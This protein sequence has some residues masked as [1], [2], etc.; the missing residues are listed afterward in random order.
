[1]VIQNKI[2]GRLRLQE[3]G[4]TLGPGQII[5]LDEKWSPEEQRKSRELRGVI[6]K[7]SVLVLSQ[8]LLPAPKEDFTETPKFFRFNTT[9]STPL[10]STNQVLRRA[11]FVAAG[12]AERN[13]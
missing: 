13:V 9:P 1:M 8:G 10:A 2:G 11:V 4:I 6:A 7:R 12:G 3:F 5:D